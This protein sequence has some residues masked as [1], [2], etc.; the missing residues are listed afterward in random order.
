MY[1]AVSCC[2]P[3]SGTLSLGSSPIVEG[4][5][6]AFP[7]PSSKDKIL[8][9][10][11]MLSGPPSRHVWLLH[12]LFPGC[13]LLA[14]PSPS[15]WLS[16]SDP[17][18]V[19]TSSF[20]VLFRGGEVCFTVEGCAALLQVVLGSSWDGGKCGHI[21]SGVGL[22]LFAFRGPLYVYIYVYIYIYIYIVSLFI[23]IYI[24]M[25]RPYIPS[26]RPSDCSCVPPPSVRPSVRP[27]TH[28][29]Y[30]EDCFF[31]RLFL[32]R[33]LC[34]CVF[35]LHATLLRLVLGSSWNRRRCGHNKNVDGMHV[36]TH[37]GVQHSNQTH[38]VH[39][40]TL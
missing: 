26:V 19:I 10:W 16:S 31:G 39:Y 32:G 12:V 21:E 40:R 34:S 25:Y 30:V 13:N 22:Y 7:S 37:R 8:F 27:V 28:I 4:V 14:R 11:N 38:S 20:R 3:G 2:D 35:A 1:I 24:Y 36:C 29:G 9:F 15:C 18:F 5:A 33:L 6:N 17:V 23:Y